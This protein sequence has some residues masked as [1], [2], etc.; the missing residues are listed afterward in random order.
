MV[1]LSAVIITYNEEGNIERC[2]N[3]LKNIADEVIVVDSY[4][5][6]N[7]VALAATQGAKVIQRIFN[8]YG[9]QKHFAQLQA[10]NDWILSLDAD[11]VVS[12]EL[13]S[14]IL[15]VKTNPRFNAYEVNIL[16]NYC[17]HW[18]RHCG[19]YPEPKIR[20]W[21]RT[22][23]AMN[24]NMVHEEWML[25]DKTGRI[26]HLKGDLLHYSYRTVSDHVRKLEQYSELK[27]RAAVAQGKKV[28]LLMVWLAPKWAFFAN[29]F[30][31][32]GFL[33]G[34]YGYVVCKISSF[35][36]YAKYIKVWQYSREKNN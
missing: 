8:G 17:G 27:A 5:T 13:E 11:E 34:Y 20:L 14:S 24:N 4:S 12:P 36:T 16:P 26:G 31:K 19:W 32:A 3:S 22:K 33:D 18:I 10:A 6:D 29:Y 28:T 7:T 9:E 35:Y 25:N 1:L 2:I 21:N 30:L 23:G 15:E